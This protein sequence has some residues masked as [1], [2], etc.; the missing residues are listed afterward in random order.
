MEAK[1]RYEA[2]KIKSNWC[3]WDNKI[4]GWVAILEK[5]MAIQ[6]AKLMNDEERGK[7]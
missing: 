4:N 2:K 3:V 1:E 6:A 7:K 5:D